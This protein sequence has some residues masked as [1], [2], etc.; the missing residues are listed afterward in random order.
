[1]EVQLKKQLDAGGRSWS[2]QVGLMLSNIISKP[3]W[4]F[5]VE[6]LFDS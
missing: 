2:G 4:Q 1:M 5:N 3:P 6:P